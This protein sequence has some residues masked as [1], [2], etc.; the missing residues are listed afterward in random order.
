MIR[1][2]FS[3]RVIIDSGA[4]VSPT[5]DEISAAV[6][7]VF[8]EVEGYFEVKVARDSIK[9]ARLALDA[10]VEGFSGVVICGGDCSF[11][12]TAPILLNTTATLG[13]VRAGRTNL[14]ADGLGVPAS[15]EASLSLVKPGRFKRIDV[16]VIAD[17]YFFSSAG[18]GFDIDI[19]RR[20][21]GEARWWKDIFSK[22]IFER[23]KRK[24]A[25]DGRREGVL[26]KCGEEST[27]L[28]PLLVRFANVA[29][30][31]AIEIAPGADPSD[32]RLDVCFMPKP[33]PR[34]A[35]DVYK[36]LMSPDIGRIPGFTRIQTAEKIEISRGEGAPA[37]VDGE[38]FDAQKNFSVSLLPGA[39]SVWA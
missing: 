24:S 19:A 18:I 26:I 14:I 22:P 12:E 1:D 20:L 13:V 34:D 5:P 3:I 35:S 25:D 15:V 6:R 11:R 38:P 8:G 33:A 36:A 16:G 23:L 39:L 2:Y 37:H 32:G 7:K 9:P 31:G 30:W 27:R 28:V 21:R 17:R 10:V 4:C 29:R